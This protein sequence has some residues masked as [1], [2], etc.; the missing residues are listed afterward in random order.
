VSDILETSF[1]LSTEEG[2]FVAD[3]YA[4]EVDQ[5]HIEINNFKDKH[6]T[7]ELDEESAKGLHAYL[8]AWLKARQE[9]KD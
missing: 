8:T 2:E 3:G 4:G 9:A 6:A 5:V 7:W 1:Y